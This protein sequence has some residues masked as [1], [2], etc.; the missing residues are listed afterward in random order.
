M[1]AEHL[2]LS[3][4]KLRLLQAGWTST[5]EDHR[6]VFLLCSDNHLRF[7]SPKDPLIPS[8]VV[9]LSSCEQ[10]PSNR[11]L[12]VAASLGEAVVSIA[13]ISAHSFLCLRA[14]GEIFHLDIGAPVLSNPFHLTPRSS[15]RRKAKVSQPLQYSPPRDNNYGIADFVHLSFMWP[16]EAVLPMV[17]LVMDDGVVY[18]GVLLFDGELVPDT[19]HILETFCLQELKARPSQDVLDSASLSKMFHVSIFF[20]ILFSNTV[21]HWILERL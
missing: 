16:G 4:P 19:V 12:S 1:I 3:S 6:S 2:F 8:L 11:S 20:Y 10:S 5:A 15:E 21:S 14:N 9:P 17:V 7:Y 13:P 18:H